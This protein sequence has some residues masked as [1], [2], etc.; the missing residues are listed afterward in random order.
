MSESKKCPECE[1]Q[2]SYNDLYGD[3]ASIAKCPKC[4]QLVSIY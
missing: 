4:G 3:Y 2:L 1:V